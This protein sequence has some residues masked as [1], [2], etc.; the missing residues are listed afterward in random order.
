MIGV[1]GT[2]VARGAGVCNAPRGG[3][4]AP[5]K[6]PSSNTC[7]RSWA[8]CCSM[9]LEAEAA[10]VD[11][12]HMEVVQQTIQDGGGQDLVAG[13]L[14]PFAD[15]ARSVV[16]YLR[17]CSRGPSAASSRRTTS[18]RG[19]A[20]MKATEKPFCTALT[21]SPAAR[22][23][24]PTPG[25]PAA[26]AAP[27]PC[28]ARIRRWPTGRCTCV[29]KGVGKV[30]GS[31][32]RWGRSSCQDSATD[33]PVRTAQALGRFAHRPIGRRL[34]VGQGLEA[35]VGPDQIPAHVP[36]PPLDLALVGGPADPTGVRHE[37]Q[38]PGVGG[39]VVVED[40]PRPAAADHGGLAVVEAHAPGHPLHGLEGA[41]VGFLLPLVEPPLHRPHARKAE[42]QAEGAQ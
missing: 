13:H 20:L 9:S 11:L 2:G 17:R 6:G 10:A 3:A 34:Q 4:P 15:A 5:T 18:T 22:W 8:S 38:L 36:Q 14:R 24:L 16:M 30:W 12:Q 27:L 25:A 21:P 40:R 33:W 19:S 35:L 29:S 23:D 28:G 26:A 41:I 32:A 31:G 42:R 1:G 7:H 39:V 37:G